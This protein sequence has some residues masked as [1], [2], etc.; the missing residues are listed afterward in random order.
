MLW[1]NIYNIKKNNNNNQKQF[2]IIFTFVVES[3]TGDVIRYGC[4]TI[5]GCANPKTD[6]IVF[7]LF[8]L[9]LIYY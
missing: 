3:T 5:D 6:E 7:W 9:N 4:V 1:L 2:T 8:P